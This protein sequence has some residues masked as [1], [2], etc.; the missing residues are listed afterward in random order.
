MSITDCYE[1]LRG[2]DFIIEA[3]SEDIDIKR[4]VFT[5]LSDITDTSTFLASNTSSLSITELSVLVKDPGYVFGLHFFNPAPVMKLTEVVVGLTTYQESVA[6]A[7]K[8]AKKLDKEPIVVNDSPGFVVNRLLIPMI[9][10]A[11]CI[12]AE[13]VANAEEI[14]KALR[15]GANHPIGPL[16]LADFI[17]NDVCLAIMEN[18]QKDTGDP[19]YRV[20]SLLRKMVR[21]KLLGRKTGKG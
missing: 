6:W 7:I 16:S 8:F 2:L 19:K 15:M 20:H 11:I 17:G 18:L 9:N 12:L 10:E 21:A 13:G 4:Q 1:K 3:V 5:K 14:D